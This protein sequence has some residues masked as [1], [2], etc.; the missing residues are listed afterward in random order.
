MLDQYDPRAD[1]AQCDRCALQRFRDGGPVQSELRSKSLFTV[2]AEA[3]AKSEVEQGR[4]LVGASGREL[5]ARLEAAALNRHHV[6]LVNAVACRCPSNSFELLRKAMREYNKG[7]KGL[8]RLVDPVT[9]CRPRLLKDLEGASN[10]LAMGTEAY[11]AIAQSEKSISMVRGGPVEG[12]LDDVGNWWEFTPKNPIGG[13]QVKLLPTIHPA[14]VLRSPKW[15]ETLQGDMARAI[16]F[17]RGDLQPLQFKLKTVPTPEELEA[18]LFTSQPFFAWDVET[19]GREPINA[20][21]RCFGV[22]TQTEAMVVPFLSRDGHTRF[23]TPQVELELKALLK[24]WLEDPGIR[25]VGHNAGAYDRIVARH[26]LHADY[27]GDI[28]TILLHQYVETELPHGLGHVASRYLDVKA[29]KSDRTAMTAETDEQLWEYNATDCVVTAQITPPLARSVAKRK[30]EP[31]VALAHRVQRVCA[32]LHDIGVAVDQVRRAKHDRELLLEAQALQK[33]VLELAG[34]G[35]DFN[36]NSGPQVR[37]LLY[38]RWQL[39][40][41]E[42]TKLGDPSTSDDALRRLRASPFTSPQQKTFIDAMRKLRLAVK[43]RGTYVRNLLPDSVE[44]STYDPF[45]EDEEETEDEIAER[46]ARKQR[47]YGLVMR[48]GRV[49][50]IYNAHGTNTGRLSSQRPNMQNFKKFLRD[51]I[52]PA[53]GHI[54]VAADMDQLELRFA[55]AL[56]GA[57]RYLRVFET[58]GDP[59]NET[60]VSIFGEGVWK[61]TPED[62][63]KLRDFAKRFV[64]A[65]LYGAS[66]ETVHEVITSAED[67]K[68]N[69][70][71][72]DVTLAE[73]R[74]R[75]NNWLDSNPEFRTWWDK[76][77]NDYGANGYLD[78]PIVGGRCDF[79]DGYED[80]RTKNKL[81]NYRC[82]RGGAMVVFEAMTELCEGPLRYNCFGQNTGL[83]TNG[84]DQL[85]FEVPLAKARWTAGVVEEAMRRKYPNLPVLFT[86]TAKSGMRFSEV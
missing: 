62:R 5:Q 50:S 22:S 84:H 32:D 61:L 77:I 49:H 76:E 63:K 75:Y 57:K 14:F 34:V 36:P 28:D 39:P 4:P 12:Y 82:Q 13:R 47:K 59:H 67:D 52:I 45:A 41:E 29:W 60:M 51:M 31:A 20:R 46:I 19:D 23:Y 2:V 74:D 40:V 55:S 83:V 38:G 18:F 66:V 43:L 42:I 53:P 64:Y 58:G 16:R 25:K 78:D 6:S 72:A 70:L 68:G 79:M 17:F 56:A 81:L 9:A 27:F 48:D 71:F 10:I 85:M 1:G 37:D 69:L 26:Q 15:R 24:R 33:Q 65:V 54:F 30:Q 86:A 7:K 3:P 11:Q 8:D 80:R 44:I 35:D 21:L 73:T